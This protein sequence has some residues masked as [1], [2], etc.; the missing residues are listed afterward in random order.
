[1]LPLDDRLV[2]TGILELEATLAWLEKES[3][4]ILCR[5][6][7]ELQGWSK[8]TLQGWSK[9]RYFPQQPVCVVPASVDIPMDLRFLNT[10]RPAQLCKNIIFLK[11]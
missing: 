6:N 8:M 9:M 2:G 5:N 1:M 10:H 4:Y 11:I 3:N 7:Y